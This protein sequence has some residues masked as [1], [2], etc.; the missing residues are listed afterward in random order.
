MRR[1]EIVA[2]ARRW[3]GTPYHHEGRVLGHGVDCIGL[4][5]CVAQACGVAVDEQTGYAR[6][7]DEARL[8]AGLDRYALRVPLDQAQPGDIVA[9]PFIRKVRHLAILTDKGMIHAYETAGGVV[10][11]AVN[12]RWRRQFSRAYSLPGVCNG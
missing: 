8:L 10:E 7:P 11:H 2:E 9:I 3:L 4:V 5:L 1:A 12:D 6:V